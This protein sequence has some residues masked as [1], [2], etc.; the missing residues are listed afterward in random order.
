MRDLWFANEDI[1]INVLSRLS[2]KIL[3]Q[4]KCVS[5][6]WKNLISDRSFIRIQL[7][8]RE[9]VS[10]F[11]FQER[12]QWSDND[13]G[14]INYIPVEGEGEKV[15]RTVLNFLPEK[16]VILSSI[17]GL[18]CC[19]SCFSSFPP[20]L[21]VCNPLNKQWTTLQW[22]DLSRSSSLSLAFDPLL[23]AA[24]YPWLLILSRIQL[25]LLQ[26]SKWLQLVILRP[27]KRI[28]I[29]YL[30]YILQKLGRGEDRM[31]FVNASIN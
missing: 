26:I 3:H 2:A 28:T 21:Y 12:F 23:E 20:R 24:A 6:E 19:R 1:H 9:A 11:F 5:K 10:G 14:F 29:S 15:W 4:M 31:N 7:K 18:I 16:V 25:M 27:E 30:M 17:N 8:N 22:P 13:I